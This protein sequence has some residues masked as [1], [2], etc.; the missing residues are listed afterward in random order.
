METGTNGP[1]VGGTPEIVPATGQQDEKVI[2]T[3]AQNTEDHDKQ[4]PL[5]RH[6]AKRVVAGGICHYVSTDDI[7]APSI[8]QTSPAT[9]P[10]LLSRSSQISGTVV[11]HAML[12][13]ST[14]EKGKG[15][16]FTALKAVYNRLGA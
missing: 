12:S 15:G 9:L 3:A 8:G 6:W 1:N 5:K 10:R 4:R 13:T 11:N 16:L 14:I 2:A 7:V